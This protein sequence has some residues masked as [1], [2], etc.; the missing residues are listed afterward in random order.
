MPV[1]AIA[2]RRTSSRLGS[3]TLRADAAET[4]LCAWLSVVLLVGLPSQRHGRVV[5]G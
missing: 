1:L 3:E 2:K 5:V 4:M